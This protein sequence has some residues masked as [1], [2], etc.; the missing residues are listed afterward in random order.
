VP[1]I[2]DTLEAI[3]P[4]SKANGMV[5]TP[6][7]TYL[8]SAEGGGIAVLD[9]STGQT[10]M[11]FPL[12]RF[13]LGREGPIA[14]RMRLDEGADP[15]DEEDD[16]LLLAAGRDGLWAT[17]ASL[18][19]LV[20]GVPVNTVRIDDSGNMLGADQ[21]SRRWCCDVNFVRVGGND[22]VAALFQKKNQSRLRFYLLSDVHTTFADGIE[23]GNELVADL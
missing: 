22:Y 2:L 6:D 16:I 3:Y 12:K 19:P 1:V 18:A 14:V 5:S 4:F 7:G 17:S 21:Y 10:G 9:T 11:D 8:Y 13:A 23:T 15:L 20:V